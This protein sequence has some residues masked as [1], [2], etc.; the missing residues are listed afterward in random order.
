MAV[1]GFRAAAVAEISEHGERD[2]MKAQ[3]KKIT[4]NTFQNFSFDFDS[5]SVEVNEANVTRPV[6]IMLHSADGQEITFNMAPGDAN[7]FAQEV[8]TKAAEGLRHWRPSA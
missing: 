6:S 3:T 4:L 7:R 5:F 8:I 1:A 2:P